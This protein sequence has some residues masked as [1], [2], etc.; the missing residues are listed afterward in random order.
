MGDKRTPFED[1]LERCRKK[2]HGPRQE[3]VRN[4]GPRGKNPLPVRMHESLSS[5]LM[6]LAHNVIAHPLSELLYW[7][8]GRKETELGRVIHDLTV[9]EE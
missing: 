2:I 3:P 9:P 7:L 4:D 1:E 5:D 6:W 8:N